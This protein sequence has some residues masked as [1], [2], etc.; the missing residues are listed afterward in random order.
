MKMKLFHVIDGYDTRFTA[1]SER[2]EIEGDEL[3][4]GE[5]GTA[6]GSDGNVYRV[7]LEKIPQKDYSDYSELSI[8]QIARKIR[9]DWK[10]PSIAAFPY[11]NA[12][13]TM[14]SIDDNYF[15]DNGRAIVNY[16]LY[17]ASSWKGAV[18]REIK[19]ELNKRVK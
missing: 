8:A 14:D 17:N 10:Q 19:K 4:I 12:M 13:L 15:Q 7:R 3:I 9:N 16:F 11:L 18:A 2:S 5:V 6:I 1:A